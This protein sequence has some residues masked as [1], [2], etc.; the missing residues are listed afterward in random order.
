MLEWDEALSAQ[1]QLESS[2]GMNRGQGPLKL[3]EDW[4]RFIRRHVI[5]ELDARA[6]LSRPIRDNSHLS[7]EAL[8]CEAAKAYG[9]AVTWATGEFA[10]LLTQLALGR[11][12]RR[13]I[14][15]KVRSAIWGETIRFGNELCNEY[16][17]DS[18]TRHAGVLPAVASKDQA[19]GD[20]ERKACQDRLAMYDREWLSEADRRI[21]L[22]ILLA[23]G[24]ETGRR[25]DPLRGEIARL[26]LENPSADDQGLC[27][28]MDRQNE[29]SLSRSRDNAGTG[30]VPFPLPEFLERKGLRLWDDAF[31]TDR[32]QE[33]QR[34]HE[35]L[36]KIRKQFAIQR[37]IPT[38][39]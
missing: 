25:I 1:A 3:S 35:L 2:A 18:W 7:K 39:G 27:K 4:V 14:S 10:D 23:G 12:K 30:R 28:E 9:K 33:A 15:E 11:T 5:Q 22:R 21:V 29:N 36:S 13:N 16:L 24:A 8:A 26:M 37:E 20:F 34:V 17:V 32:E 31:G 19:F 38:S 6:A